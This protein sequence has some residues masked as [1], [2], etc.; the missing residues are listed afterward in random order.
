MARSGLSRS[1]SPSSGCCGK[2]SR[3]RGAPTPSSSSCSSH[4]GVYRQPRAPRP[5]AAHA[6][7]RPGRAGCIGLT[8]IMSV[9]VRCSWFVVQVP[10]SEFQFEVPASLNPEPLNP[11]PEPRT[12]N[13]E[14]RTGYD[15]AMT[16]IDDRGLIVTCPSCQQRNRVPFGHESAQAAKCKKC[17]TPLPAAAEPVEVPTA[18]VFDALVAASGCPSS[19]ISGRRGAGRAGW[20][21]PSSRG[22]PR[23]NAGRYLVVKVNTDAVPELGDRFGIRSIPTMAVFVGGREVAR[24]SG[25]RPGGGHRA[26]RGAGPIGLVPSFHGPGRGS[27]DNRPRPS[28][29]SLCRRTISLRCGA[30]ARRVRRQQG[31]LQPDEPALESLRSAFADDLRTRLQNL[32]PTERIETTPGVEAPARFA[33]AIDELASACDGFF[34]RAALR[35][36]LTPDERREILARHGAHA[37][38]RQPAQDVLHRRRSPLRRG[39]RSRARAFVRSDR[40]RS[41]RRRFGCGAARAAVTTTPGAAT[42]SRRSSATSA[43][44]WRCGPTSETVRMVLTAQMGKAGP[45]M[46]GKDLHI[47]DIDAAASCPPR[48]RSRSAR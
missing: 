46:D 45:P 30:G 11:E 44:R 21:R 24:T 6:A 38:H 26:I 17:G 39:R 16:G 36:S 32:A 5:P 13:N 18:E 27:S 40:R 7:D 1:P 9:S 48:R 10:G 25:A 4:P 15:H 8:A 35:A 42:S 22:W 14:P 43:R 34:A 23:S 33:L 12:K 3:K 31:R 20:W 19:S 37:R 29:R 47:G 2:C 28:P 41:T